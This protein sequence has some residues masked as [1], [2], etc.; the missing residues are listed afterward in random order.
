MEISDPEKIG[1]LRKR[2][3]VLN[4]WHSRLHVLK[5][6]FLFYFADNK[7]REPRFVMGVYACA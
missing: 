5:D 3:D 4:S 2:G 7:Q 6:C 1:F